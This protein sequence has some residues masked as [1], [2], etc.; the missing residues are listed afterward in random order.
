MFF[1]DMTLFQYDGHISCH[2]INTWW[3][4]GMYLAL[5]ELAMVLSTSEMEIRNHKTVPILN[6]QK[7]I[8]S[9]TKIWMRSLRNSHVVGW[10]SCILS[11]SSIL[12]KFTR[13]KSHSAYSPKTC[14]YCRHSAFKAAKLF[15]RYSIRHHKYQLPSFWMFQGGGYSLNVEF[16]NLK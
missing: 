6:H 14:T 16:Q 15:L 7:F 13:V 8:G 12:V 5:I 9:L 1:R 4:I 10:R 2:Q 3:H 11:H